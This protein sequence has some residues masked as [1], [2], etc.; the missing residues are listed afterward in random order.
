SPTRFVPLIQIATIRMQGGSGTPA[1][2]PVEQEQ[3]AEPTETPAAP[4]GPGVTPE[5][6]PVAPAATPGEVQ[7]IP[8][9]P[10]PL[11]DA[12]DACFAGDDWGALPAAPGLSPPRVG[13]EAL[14]PVPERAAVLAALL[15][16]LGGYWSPKSESRKHGGAG[17]S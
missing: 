14:D 3:A 1:L 10:R 13:A 11:S 5:A 15:V 4:A 17:V 12:H 16:V 8:A 9:L 2:F 7:P 6:V